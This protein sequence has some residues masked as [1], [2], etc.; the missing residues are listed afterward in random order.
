MNEPS[1]SSPSSDFV[2]ASSEYGLVVVDWE[3]CEAD[4]GGPIG[5]NEEAP[6]EERA[7]IGM[8]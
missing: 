2:S 1:S 7:A 4:A 6:K 3:G 5:P 8:N